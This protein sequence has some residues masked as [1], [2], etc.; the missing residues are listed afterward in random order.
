MIN[1]HGDVQNVPVSRAFEV[2]HGLK[3]G[4]ITDELLSSAAL[5]IAYMYVHNR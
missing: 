5:I 4:S 2:D 3:V 1:G